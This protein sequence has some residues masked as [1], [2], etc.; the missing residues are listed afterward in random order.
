MIEW[1][2]A[3]GRDLGDVENEKGK[4]WDGKTTAL[5]IVRENEGTEA[6]SQLERFIANPGMNCE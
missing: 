2:V 3:S 6:A 4:Y 5:E 1:L